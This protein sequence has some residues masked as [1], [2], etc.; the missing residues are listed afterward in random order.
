MSSTAKTKYWRCKLENT[1][2]PAEFT[3]KAKC[4]ICG[5]EVIM[6]T[7]GLKEHAVALMAWRARTPCDNCHGSDSE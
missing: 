6:R 7:E 3:I 4:R 5:N 2:G 1:V